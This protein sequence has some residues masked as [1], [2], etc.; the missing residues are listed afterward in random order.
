[1]NQSKHKGSQVKRNSSKNMDKPNQNNG[2]KRNP[3]TEKRKA[4]E[5][6]QNIN[7]QRRKQQAKNNQKI[8]NR[9]K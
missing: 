1:M 2:G 3:I 8:P 6:Q 4:K 5:R 9:G 7:V